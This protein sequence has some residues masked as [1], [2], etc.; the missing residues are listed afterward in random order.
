MLFLVKHPL[1]PD[2]T[3]LAEAKDQEEARKEFGNRAEI[4]AVTEPM[5]LDCKILVVP[6]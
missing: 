3:I 1:N 2:V 5:R 4:S 6:R